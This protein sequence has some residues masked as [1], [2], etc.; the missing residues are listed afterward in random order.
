MEQISRYFPV[1]IA[2]LLLLA[3]GIEGYFSLASPELGFVEARVSS[4]CG[5][6]KE[7]TV[8]ECVDLARALRSLRVQRWLVASVFVLAGAIAALGCLLL[9]SLDGGATQ[10]GARLDVRRGIAVTALALEVLAAAALLG[11]V[12]VAAQWVR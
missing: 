4:A 10:A 12:V 3:G 9:Q 5:Q 7:A 2:L 6:T 1:T 8:R 11:G